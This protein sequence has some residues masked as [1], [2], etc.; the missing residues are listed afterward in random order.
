MENKGLL[1]KSAMFYGLLLGTFWIIK[2]IF[3]ILGTTHPAMG[4]VY[5]ILTSLTIVFAYIFTKVYKI[6][7][8]GRIGFFHA[9][10]FGILLYFFAALIVSLL[11]YVFFRHLAP[12]DYV[13]NM[14]DAAVNMIKEINPQAEEALNGMPA[15]TPIRLTLQGIL[16]NVFYGIILSLPVA[17]LLCRGRITGFILPENQENQEQKQ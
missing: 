12:P 6:L 8:G 14:I 15:F 3:F 5:W 11:H 2:Y 9:W 17:T 4:F 1:L 10:Q 7:I 13:A 16:N